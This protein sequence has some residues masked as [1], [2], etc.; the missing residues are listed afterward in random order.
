LGWLPNSGTLG[1]IGVGRNIDDQA[2]LRQG[3]C[4]T[5]PGSG[6]NIAPGKP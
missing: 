6:E 5:G 3:L 4:I 1:Q 2:W